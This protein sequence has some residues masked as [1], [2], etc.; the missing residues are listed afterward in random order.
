MPKSASLKLLR[1]RP[2][3]MRV[4][5]ISEVYSQDSGLGGN[6]ES[7]D[8]VGGEVNKRRTGGPQGSDQRGHE[9]FA[10]QTLS[11]REQRRN[12]PSKES[13]ELL[14]P[15]VVEVTSPEVGD[16]AKVQLNIKGDKVETL[17]DSVSP[18]SFSDTELADRLGLARCRAPV[19]KFRGVISGDT[20]RSQ[21]ATEIDIEI[22]GN[23]HRIPVYVT[24]ALD[25]ELILGF[26]ILRKIST[27]LESYE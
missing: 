25:K 22:D 20:A 26:P 1:P 12:I 3:S 11:E 4:L 8:T 19:L 18:T 27:V 2:R 24:S 16:V 15:I 10:S 7:R 13:C 6:P 21:E 14:C 5:A 23:N 9:E 17:F